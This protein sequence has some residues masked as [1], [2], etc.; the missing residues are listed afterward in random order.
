MS[1]D[2]EDKPQEVAWRVVGVC[3]VLALL[4]LITCSCCQ[5]CPTYDRPVLVDASAI[6][7]CGDHWCVTDGW[8]AT[9]EQDEAALQAALRQCLDSLDSCPE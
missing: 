2:P 5:T 9:H 7:R 6:W 4:A 8:M 1:Y 3:L